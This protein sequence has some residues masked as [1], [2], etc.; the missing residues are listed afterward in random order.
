MLLHDDEAGTSF[1]HPGAIEMQRRLATERLAAHIAEKYV[2]AEL[3]DSDIEVVTAADCFYLATADAFGQPDCSYKGGLPGFVR[4]IDRRTVKFPHYDGNGMF[5]SLG[6]LLVNP[7]VGMLFIDYEHPVKLRING[8]AEVSTE[9]SQTVQFEGADAVIT[10]QVAQ[11]FENC[12]RY[13]HRRA[14]GEHSRHCPRPG[15]VPPDPEWKLK[16]EYDGIVR[17][18]GV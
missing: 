4:V 8:E 18:S 14:T 5:R 11:V 9:A 12:P 10:V 6:N 15:Y 16:P 2:A 3:S 13:L 1:Y 17:R 7:R